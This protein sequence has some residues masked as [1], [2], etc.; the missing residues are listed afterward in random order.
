[1]EP[2]LE[3]NRRALVHFAVSSEKVYMTTTLAG[4]CTRFLPFNTGNNDGAGNPPN[5]QGYR[6]A[7]LWEKVLQ[8]DNWLDILGR[9]LHVSTPEP[10]LDEPKPQPRI[11]FP[12]Y[13]QW[14]A[15]RSLIHAT[16]EEGAGHP[17]R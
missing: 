13:H 3:P 7:Y 2:L 10:T 12:L 14:D 1:M 15:V 9:F 5:P 17:N 6:T 16:R 8:R 4:Q 11:I